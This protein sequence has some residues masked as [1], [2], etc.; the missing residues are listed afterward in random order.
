MGIFGGSS[1][2]SQSL[3]N[4]IT[5]NPVTNIGDDN[6]TDSSAE[7]RSEARSTATTKDEFGLSAG[8]AFGGGDATGG[9]VSDT[10][11]QPMQ[12][13]K[14]SSLPF[15]QDILLYGGLGVAVLGGAYYLLKKKGK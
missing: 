11:T 15:N 8:V 14:S 10:D 1:S 12:T 2:S 3:N 4:A 13:L 7:Q 5:F 9:E 6:D